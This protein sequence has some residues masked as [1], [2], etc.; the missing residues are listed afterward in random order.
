MGTA[1]LAILGAGVV[2]GVIVA[3]IAQLFGAIR[4]GSRSPAHA[5]AVRAR[6][7]RSPCTCRNV[8]WTGAS[9]VAIAR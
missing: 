5:A 1:W 2:A 3:L 9:S 6:S 8:A 4:P 7:T